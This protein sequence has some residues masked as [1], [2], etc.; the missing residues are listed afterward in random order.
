MK[1]VSE[2]EDASRDATIG[3]AKIFRKSWR[4]PRLSGLTKSHLRVKVGP[5]QSQNRRKSVKNQ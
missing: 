1:L 2:E 3:A 5:D 4:P